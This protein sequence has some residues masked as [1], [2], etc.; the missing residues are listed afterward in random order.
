MGF[1][2]R[3]KNPCT[4]RSVLASMARKVNAPLHGFFRPAKKPM[5]FSHGFSHFCMIFLE[6]RYKSIFFSGN[7]S[8]TSLHVSFSMG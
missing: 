2:V 3:R 5:Q 7:K 8:D 1:I 4:F 6:E